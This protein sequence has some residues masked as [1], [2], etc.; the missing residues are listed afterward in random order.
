MNAG[1]HSSPGCGWPPAWLLSRLTAPPCLGLLICKAGTI[2]PLWGSPGDWSCWQQGSVEHGTVGFLRVVGS[3]LG[4]GLLARGPASSCLHPSLHATLRP[5]PVLPLPEALPRAEQPTTT[6]VTPQAWAAC[7]QPPSVP[8]ACKAWHFGMGHG[9]GSME[10]A[11]RA[12][13]HHGAV[14]LQGGICRQAGPAPIPFCI[15]FLR[16]VAEGMPGQGCSGKL[17]RQECSGKLSR[18]GLGLQDFAVVVEWAQE[19]SSRQEGFQ[20][21]QAAH[22]LSRQPWGQRPWSPSPQLRGPLEALFKQLES[23]LWHPVCWRVVTSPET[24]LFLMLLVCQYYCGFPSLQHAGSCKSQPVQGCAGMKQRAEG[25]DSS[26]V[27]CINCLET[28]SYSVGDYVI[29]SINASHHHV[30]HFLFFSHLDCASV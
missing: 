21:K 29:L 18:H 15:L 25:I 8:S 10:G 2:I 27:W 19:G 26:M 28:N 23:K 22:I 24:V 12:E 20:E 9:V 16:S 3:D 13:V 11:S 5:N 4:P 14:L 17:S 30:L 1:K 6:W 7:R